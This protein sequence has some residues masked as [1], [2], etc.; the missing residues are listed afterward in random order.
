[1]TNNQICNII[2]VFGAIIC[3]F[4]F[5]LCFFGVSA[6]IGAF[7]GLALIGICQFSYDEL[8]GPP[9]VKNLSKKIFKSA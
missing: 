1:M 8:A 3:F 2:G 4:C 6:W 5:M 7:F 9:L